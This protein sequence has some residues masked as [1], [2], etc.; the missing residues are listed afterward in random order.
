V[1]K[2]P[3][4]IKASS[5]KVYIPPMGT[6]NAEIVSNVGS[7]RPLKGVY[8]DFARSSMNSAVSR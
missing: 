4:S 2:T 5:T 7:A 6:Y 8:I 3:R 1:F